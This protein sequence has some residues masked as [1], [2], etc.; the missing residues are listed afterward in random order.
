M[1][2]VLRIPLIFFAALFVGQAFGKYVGSWIRVKE[3][4]N[5]LES[6]QF[7]LTTAG[8][9]R[10]QFPLI[11]TEILSAITGMNNH[12]QLSASVHT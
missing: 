10:A 9:W 11:G 7:V 6:C 3:L 1:K 4:L 8:L 5:P 12:V 2:Q